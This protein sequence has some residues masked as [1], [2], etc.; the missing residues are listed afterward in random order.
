MRTIQTWVKKASCN[1][2]GVVP[3]KARGRPNGACRKLS[4]EDELWLLQR[5]SSTVPDQLGLPFTLWSTQVVQ[6]LICSRFGIDISDR[7]VR[8][9]LERW[10]YVARR[11]VK[12]YREIPC[13]SVQGWFRTCYPAI[14]LRA[15]RY[16][17]RGMAGTAQGT[18]R[19]ILLAV[20]RIVRIASLRNSTP[21]G[22]NSSGL[23]FRYRRYRASP[24]ICSTF[25]NLELLRYFVC[26]KDVPHCKM[27][28]RATKVDMGA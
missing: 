8:K 4:S 23:F 14:T 15:V 5:I 21:K 11:S 13:K 10:G 25:Q 2:N 20:V 17:D 16:A 28:F 9:Y 12:N 24:P 3:E 22:R 26:Q 27:L 19:I 18:D 1:P 7:L 6:T